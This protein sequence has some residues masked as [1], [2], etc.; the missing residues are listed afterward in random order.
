MGEEAAGKPPV[1][2]LREETNVT[3]G[4]AVQE[5]LIAA[6]RVFADL[7]R[8]TY[9]P[10]GLDKM[11]YKTDGTTAVTNDGA[12]IVSELM[13]KHPA[14][15]MFVAMAESQE[16]S[17]GDGVTGTLL[18]CAELLLEA[19]R[20][21][22]KGLHPLTVI[23]GYNQANA[24]ALDTISNLATTCSTK[25]LRQVA[26]TAL[27]GK[28]AEGASEHLSE[29]IV[30]ALQTV[31]ADPDYVTMHKVNSGGLFD[32][33]ILHGIVVRRRV[34][35]DALPSKIS[36][37]KV[38]TINGDLAPRK[39]IRTAEI[40]IEEASQ[41][42]AF[43]AAEEAAIISLANTLLSSGANVFLCTGTVNKGLLH[44]LMRAGCFVAGEFDDSELR[45]AS[46]A[47]GSRIIEHL[48]D[49]LPEDIGTAGRLITER[50]T[51]TDQVEDI[52][53]L[54]QCPSPGVVTCE[55]GGANH[56]AAEEAIRALHDSLRA[57]GLAMRT[58]RLVVGG[59]ATHMACALAIREAAER[60]AGRNRLAM[61][62]FARALEIVPS[63]LALNSGADALDMVLELR[64]A[65]RNGNARAGIK[66]DGTVGDTGATEAAATLESA[67]SAATETCAS[68]L[69][70]DQVVSA[71]G[72]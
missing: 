3:S 43:L 34:L 46:L 33:K 22:Q 36:D 68:M 45:N 30:E 53:R 38:A 65:H 9:G 52:I 35:L 70:I 8:P 28:G 57:T 66:S 14:G 12:K 56:L 31:N 67:I 23:E 39:Q 62:A 41:L 42:D 71:R 32:S 10:R 49:L 21:L 2:I 18:L 51:S 24:I 44:H 13:V 1:V 54:E 19:G 6:A 26:M 60:E 27:T 11:M 7:L 50:K 58:D 64:A 16:N 48:N 20:L 4:T 61:D 47:T 63:T 15:K 17:C 69:R 5:K 72:D 25:E 59:G 55:V 29:I 37:A 40:E